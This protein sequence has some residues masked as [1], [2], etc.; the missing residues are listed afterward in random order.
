MNLYLKPSLLPELQT[1]IIRDLLGTFT[2]MPYKLP[3]FHLSEEELDVP[4]TFHPVSRFTF[5]ISINNIFFCQLPMP[6]I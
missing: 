6:E 5:L 4:P 3:F 2:W 1:Y